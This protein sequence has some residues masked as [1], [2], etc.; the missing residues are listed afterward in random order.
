MLESEKVFT[1]TRMGVHARQN[2]HM[3]NQAKILA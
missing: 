1:V 3:L 2:T